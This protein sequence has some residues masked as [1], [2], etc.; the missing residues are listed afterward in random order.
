MNEGFLN[1]T[2]IIVPKLA[3]SAA[4]YFWQEQRIVDIWCW[5]L[6]FG[7]RH[8]WRRLP[9][10]KK[11]NPLFQMEI[12]KESCEDLFSSETMVYL[13]PDAEEG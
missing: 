13:T 8:Y 7:M 3:Q 9:N 12:T 10:N 2:V 11:E 6:N 5:V 4:E 1:Y